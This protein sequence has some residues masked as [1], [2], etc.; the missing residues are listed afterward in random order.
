MRGGGEERE[1]NSREEMEQ[2]AA[3][4]TEEMKG[5]EFREGADRH[6]FIV[7]DLAR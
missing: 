3:D 1:P 4:L 2:R 5:L 6:L 7:S